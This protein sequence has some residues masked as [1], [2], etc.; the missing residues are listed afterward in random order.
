MLP[1]GESPL[2]Y[3]LQYQQQSSAYHLIVAQPLCG[4]Y[5]P[6]QTG[7]AEVHVLGVGVLGQVLHQGLNIHVIVIIYVTEPP[8]KQNSY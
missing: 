7:F 6:V 1:S 2:K 5:W 8:A 3:I 4:L